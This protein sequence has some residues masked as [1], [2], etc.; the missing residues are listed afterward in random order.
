MELTEQQFLVVADA[1]HGRGKSREACY[2]VMVLGQR[3]C[4]VARAMNISPNLI[5]V[6]LGCYRKNADKMDAA[7]RRG[8]QRKSPHEAG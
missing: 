4:D 6:A 7:F 8:A 2:R 3:Q 5:A 1:I